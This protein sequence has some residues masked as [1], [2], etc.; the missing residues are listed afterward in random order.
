MAG[1]SYFGRDGDFRTRAKYAAV[2]IFREDAV[3]P[4]CYSH[5]ASNRRLDISMKRF[6][7]LQPFAGAEAAVVDITKEPTLKELF[8]KRRY[9][10]F[11]ALKYANFS[12]V[13]Y[14]DLHIDIHQLNALETL[15]F[16][17][18]WFPI[19]RYVV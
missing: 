13:T 5:Y 7:V 8:K 12:Y 3:S 14:Y 9:L 1:A 18:T 4:H 11:T 2:L 17:G 15:I 10:Q 16:H 6:R 19:N